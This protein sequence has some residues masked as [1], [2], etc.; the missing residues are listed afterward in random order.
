MEIFCWLEKLSFCLTTFQLSEN[1]F[2]KKMFDLHHLLISLL[3]SLTDQKLAVKQCMKSTK[4]MIV[5]KFLK[6]STTSKKVMH[7]LHNV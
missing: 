2:V 6:K 3:K 7:G 1:S 5:Y 4:S